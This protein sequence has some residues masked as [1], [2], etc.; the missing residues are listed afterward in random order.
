MKTVEV[1]IPKE[2]EK[3]FN[4]K[5]V[6]YLSFLKTLNDLEENKWTDYKLEEPLEITKFSKIL[7]KEFYGK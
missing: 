3:A 7:K 4:E 6:G 2:F 1:E 5:R